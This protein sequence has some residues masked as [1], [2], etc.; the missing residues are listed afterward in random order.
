MEKAYQEVQD[1][2]QPVIRPSYGLIFLQKYT[3]GITNILHT[4]I[5]TSNILYGQIK[6]NSVIK[7]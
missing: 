7:Y 1:D 5:S 3:R 2:Q 4:Y 6:E